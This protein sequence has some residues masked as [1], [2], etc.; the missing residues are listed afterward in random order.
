ML[1]KHKSRLELEKEKALANKQSNALPRYMRP[2][3]ASRHAAAQGT[4]LAD[5][6]LVHKSRLEREKEAALEA[7]HPRGKA[8]VSLAH[9]ILNAKPYNCRETG[10]L[11]DFARDKPNQ[12]LR[13]SSRYFVMEAFCRQDLLDLMV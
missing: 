11:E 9:N 12:H 4:S 7:A 8:K 6:L 3:A 13:L 5:S 10:K 1:R 2:T